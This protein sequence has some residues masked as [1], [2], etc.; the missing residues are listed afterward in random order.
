MPNTETLK[1]DKPGG[2]VKSLTNLYNPH[3]GT[4]AVMKDP[5]NV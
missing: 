1:T 4:C 5:W 3:E 2:I